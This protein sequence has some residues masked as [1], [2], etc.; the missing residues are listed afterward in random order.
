MITSHSNCPAIEAM[1]RR[2]ISLARRSVWVGSPRIDGDDTG[3]SGAVAQI[4]AA[5]SSWAI[6]PTRG[7]G[8]QFESGDSLECQFVA[9]LVGLE[10]RNSATLSCCLQRGQLSIEIPRIPPYSV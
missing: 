6:A 9:M 5:R 4:R 8:D 1:A 10:W 2:R 7:R 3:E